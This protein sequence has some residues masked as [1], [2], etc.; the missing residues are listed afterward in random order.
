MNK[1]RSTEAGRSYFGLA[2]LAAGLAT[3]LLLGMNYGVSQLDIIPRTFDQLNNLTALLYC[4]FTPLTFVLGI[5]GHMR[6]NDSKLLAWIAIALA[7]TPLLVLVI[8][9]IFSLSK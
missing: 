8:K 4:A 5:T 3:D 6:K 2:A 1:K 7:A 9:M